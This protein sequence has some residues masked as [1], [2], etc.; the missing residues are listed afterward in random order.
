MYYII[1]F[2]A[3]FIL[4]PFIIYYG[5][6]VVDYLIEWYETKILK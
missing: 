6:N 4:S 3:G 1:S 2:L 5:F